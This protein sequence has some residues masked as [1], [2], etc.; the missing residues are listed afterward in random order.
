MPFW[1][2]AQV[3]AIYH[4]QYKD[5]MRRTEAVEIHAACVINLPA[6]Q[7]AYIAELTHAA[8]TATLLWA[9]LKWDM[10]RWVR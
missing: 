10:I 2:A 5:P 6:K 8:N 1:S 4:K 3:T 9:Q 7:I